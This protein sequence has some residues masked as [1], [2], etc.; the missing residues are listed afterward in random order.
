MEPKQLLR[1][2]A[3]VG[4]GSGRQFSDHDMEIWY[5]LIGDL[6]ADLA[7]DAA[8]ELAR[9]SDKYITPSDV[10]AQ[11]RAIA[12]RRIARAGTPEAPPGME[13]QEYKEW[14]RRYRALVASGKV[15]E[16]SAMDASRTLPAGSSSGPTPD[17]FDF[18]FLRTVDD[19][20]VDG[21]VVQE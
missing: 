17:G 15:E 1:V 11:A 8:R 6:D 4:I 12:A 13:P 7:Y 21:E 19:D 16:A 18:S 9:T 2:T 14:L 3:M 10:R 20:A 5:D